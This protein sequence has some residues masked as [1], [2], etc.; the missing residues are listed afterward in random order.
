M[1]HPDPS[2]V[3]P[4]VA[5]RGGVPDYGVIGPLWRDLQTIRPQEEFGSTLSSGSLALV[6]SWMRECHSTHKK[7]H[8]VFRGDLIGQPVVGSAW[9]PDRLIRIT[10]AISST[11]AVQTHTRVVVKSDPADFTLA[12]IA[13]G[14]NYLSFSHCWGP[15][16]PGGRDGTVLKDNNLAAWRQYLPLPTLPKA[17]QD[18]VRVCTALEFDHIWIDSL[19]ILQ[20]NPVD[21]E[22]QAPQMADVYKFAW[23]NIAALSSPADAS[24]FINDA[25]DPRVIFGFHTPLALA[26]NLYPSTPNHLGQPCAFL[27][28]ATKFIWDYQSDLPGCGDWMAPLFT[29][30]WVYQE[31]SLSRRT[32]A[33]ATHGVHFVCDEGNHGEMPAWPGNVSAGSPRYLLHSALEQTTPQSPLSSFPKSLTQHFNSTWTTAVHSYSECHLTQPTDRLMAISS[34]AQEL[35]KVIRSRYLAGLWETQ[36]VFQLAWLTCVGRTVAPRAPVTSKGYV[37]PSWSWTSIEAPVV[38]KDMFDLRER[39][40]ADVRAVHTVLKTGFA[41]GNVTAG[42]LRMWG[43]LRGV[44]AYGLEDKSLRLT[45]AGTGER[46]WFAADTRE[47]MDV[48][49]SWN[50]TQRVVWMPLVL[51]I[52]GPTVSCTALVLVEVGVGEPLGI[53]AGSFVKP[54]ERVYRRLGTGSFG[55]IP[56]LMRQDKLVMSLGTFPETEDY[57]AILGGF[58]RNEWGYREFVII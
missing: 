49:G 24:G 50:W 18:A 15:D 27:T 55:R 29:R 28:G 6:S 34:V 30:A 25:R 32:L 39:C 14:V 37:A 51:G 21:W 3:L 11:G 4:G 19:C 36:L 23:L 44:T 45:D 7:C 31:R 47:V 10:K 48:L 57:D 1:L 9:F 5:S 16:P 42:W 13:A 53:G 38:P 17:F 22:E 43:G 26:L 54:G 35:G 20:G 33:F 52:S 40:L 8:E 2:V 46:V 12:Q 56:S 58:V 41:Y